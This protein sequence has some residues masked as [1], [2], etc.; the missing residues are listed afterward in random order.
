VA[1]AENVFGA[2]AVGDFRAVWIL[3]HRK[4]YLDTCR[5]VA[6]PSAPD[7]RVALGFEKAIARVIGTAADVERGRAL[8]AP[9]DHVVED[10]VIAAAGVD[11]LQDREIHRV[12]DHAAG[13]ARRR[14]YVLNDGIERVP[15]V[16]LA[17]GSAVELLVLTYA[18]KG[19]TPKAGGFGCLL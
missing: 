1:G 9:V 13:I 8:V 10:C 6:F 18:A 15:R 14:L 11:R 5:N 4:V 2:D 3:G 7:Q 16:D 19:L 17:C 12:L